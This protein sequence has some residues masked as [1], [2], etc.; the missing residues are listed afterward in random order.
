MKNKIYT[1]SEPQRIEY[2]RIKGLNLETALSSNITMYS[3]V[4]CPYCNKAKSFLE[5]KG[6]PHSIVEVST[7]G[8]K[9]NVMQEI[10]RKTGVM[11]P[12][13]FPMVV[14]GRQFIGGYNELKS[15]FGENSTC[16]IS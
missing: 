14:K 3:K 12:G 1:L 2:R 7:K 9:N 5:S 16:I 8:D 4:G 10:R 13:T 11:P 15:A 6:I